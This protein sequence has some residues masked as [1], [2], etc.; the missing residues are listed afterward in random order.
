MPEAHTWLQRETATDGGLEHYPE[1]GSA[2]NIGIMLVRPS[3]N[4]FAKVS[5]LRPCASECPAQQAPVGLVEP[6]VMCSSHHTAVGL[7]YADDNRLCA[8]QEWVDKILADENYWDQNAFNDLMVRGAIVEPRRKD[9]LFL[10][11]FT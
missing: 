10:C 9:R 1:A 3:C 8:L 4:D 11:A 7:R 6:S 5:S 2:A